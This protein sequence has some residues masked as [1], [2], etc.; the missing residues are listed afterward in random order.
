MRKKL[1]NLDKN[2][3]IWLKEGL[4][5]IVSVFSIRDFKVKTILLYL[6]AS[7][8]SIKRKN[9]LNLVRILYNLKIKRI[10][11]ILLLNQLLD[12]V[13]LVN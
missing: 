5:F 8:W 7:N 9:Q 1:T 11:K 3:N 12:L 6:K 4:C 2:I 13:Y 10:L